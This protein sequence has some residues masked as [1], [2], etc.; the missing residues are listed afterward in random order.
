M[1]DIN[2]GVGK[3]YFRLNEPAKAEPYFREELAYRTKAMPEDW[4][5]FVAESWIGACLLAR[6]NVADAEPCLLRAYRGMKAQPRAKHPSRPDDWKWAIRQII[7]FID[8]ARDVRDRHAFDEILAD[9]DVKSVIPDIRFPDDP[10]AS[11]VLDR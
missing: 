9:P 3:C 10:F 1:A 5:R 11:P 6:K 2:S 7:R 4:R 8:E